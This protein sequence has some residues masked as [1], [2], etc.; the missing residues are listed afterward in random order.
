MLEGFSK[1]LSKLSCWPASYPAKRGHGCYR[2]A[3]V[4][5]TA[6]EGTT[7]Y[8][9]DTPP[10]AD[11]SADGSADALP[12]TLSHAPPACWVAHLRQSPP[13]LRSLALHPPR[14]GCAAAT[15]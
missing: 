15:Q 1:S 2:G 9:D 8:A 5:P 12:L 10:P 14:K 6:V 3:A 7:R 13:K 11:G 4:A